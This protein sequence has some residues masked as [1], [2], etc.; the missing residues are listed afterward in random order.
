[1]GDKLLSEGG[2]LHSSGGTQLGQAERDK[3]SKPM[4]NMQAG[5]FK[6]D[7]RGGGCYSKERAQ[8]RRNE[9]G[10]V[11]AHHQRSD[12]MYL[13]NNVL[14]TSPRGKLCRQERDPLR[15]PYHC[16]AFSEW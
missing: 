16:R 8:Q 13:G 1:M 4:T 7:R 11:L 10:S 12:Y 6:R 5:R 14:P 9:N 2:V 3:T 15:S